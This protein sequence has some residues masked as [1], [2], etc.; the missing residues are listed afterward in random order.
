MI[1]LTLL[2]IGLAAGVLSGMFGIGGGIIIIPALTYFLDF[3]QH[4]ATGTSLAILLPPVGLAAVYE[5]YRQGNVDLKA[6]GIVAAAL[7]IGAWISASFV[8]RISD[9]MLRSLFGVFV[10]GVG[11]Y[12]SATGFKSLAAERKAG[13]QAAPHNEEKSR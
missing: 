8:S 9:G 10:V 13:E 2:A 3:S 5:F 12:L 1:Y 7:F 6:A 11:L 4:R